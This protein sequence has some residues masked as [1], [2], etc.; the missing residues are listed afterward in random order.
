[1][2]IG[3][4][5]LGYVGLTAAVGLTRFGHEVIGY[6]HNPNVVAEIHKCKTHYAGDDE[7]FE[8]MRSAVT[9]KQLNVYSG[10][11]EL[12]A[13]MDAVLICVGVNVSKGGVPNYYNLMDA[14]DSVTKV[15]TPGA[16]IIIE[17]TLPAGT[18]DSIIYP[19][20]FGHYSVAYCPERVSPGNL[21][22]NFYNMPRV[23]GVDSEQT[24]FKVQKV[25]A[26][27]LD[28]TWLGT[29]D[30]FIKTIKASY[31]DAE[32]CK[33][34]ENAYRDVM[35]AF[36]NTMAV[37]A[38]KYGGNVWKVRELINSLD[39]REMLRPGPGVGG[40][41][42]QKDTRLLAYNSPDPGLLNT[43]FHFNGWM[44]WYVA[45]LAGQYL[46][47]KVAILGVAY[48]ADVNDERNSPGYEIGKALQIYGA[49]VVYHD[50]YIDK[51][52]TDIYNRVE[53][54]E[55]VILV[56][57]HKAYKAVDYEQLYTSTKQG[58][59]LLIDTRNFINPGSVFEGWRFIQL[60]VGDGY[61]RK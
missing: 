10:L 7:L 13:D 55:A 51:H 38:E 1:M 48:K 16:L 40:Y 58:A 43:A 8:Q 46:V 19:L 20:L 34:G 37:T 56:T 6:D 44:P 39:D 26:T 45:R 59:P 24:Y 32:L 28:Y 2:K 18:M 54:C 36:A 11:G 27:R 35:L 41:C 22:Y 5:G 14:L 12:W 29:D 50:P 30:D 61:G 9:F 60:G 25:Y 15:L 53:G 23:V 4:V 52:N 47:R 49:S 3:V 33:L 17:S 42:L 31:I 21:L 57:P